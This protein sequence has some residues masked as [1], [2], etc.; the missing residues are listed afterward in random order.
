MFSLQTKTALIDQSLFQG[1]NPDYPAFHGNPRR[2]KGRHSDRDAG[3]GDGGGGGSDSGEKI[4]TKGKARSWLGNLDWRHFEPDNSSSE[5]VLTGIP[6]KRVANLRAAESFVSTK[7]YAKVPKGLEKE[8]TRHWSASECPPDKLRW[9]NRGL[10]KVCQRGGTGGDCDSTTYMLKPL[11]NLVFSC[12]NGENHWLLVKVVQPTSMGSVRDGQNKA[13]KPFSLCSSNQS[14]YEPS[15]AYL[16]Y[17]S[18]KGGRGGKQGNGGKEGAK[19]G[20]ESV[21]DPTGG[22]PLD[23]KGGEKERGCTQKNRKEGK[24]GRKGKTAKGGMDGQSE[25]VTDPSGGDLFDKILEDPEG[26]VK[27]P[28]SRPNVAG[29]TSTTKASTEQ[30][31]DT[32]YTGRAHGWA[33]IPGGGLKAG[34][35]TSDS[36]SDE[37]GDDTS[38]KSGFT[39]STPKVA[40]LTAVIGQPDADLRGGMEENSR[41]V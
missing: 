12:G 40:K 6:I 26:A 29:F 22:Q 13:N 23:K 34:N 41:K 32:A 30:S 3:S 39:H 16:K 18:P 4:T 33:K 24:K 1:D 9:A 11:L 21:I 25:D 37:D 20:S 14:L 38:Q 19:A 28:S 17:T 2:G 5:R 7:G 15:N 35:P 27:K 31:K 10:A 36:S 8:Y